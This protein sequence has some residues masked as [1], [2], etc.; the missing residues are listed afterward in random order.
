MT[1]DKIIFLIQK[2]KADEAKT[3]HFARLMNS[4]LGELHLIIGLHGDSPQDC[5][6]NFAVEY[7]EMAPRLIEC[8]EACARE[9]DEQ[10]LFQPFIDTAINYFIQP[11]VIFS[12]Y[13]GLDGLLMNAYLCHRLIEEMYENN[14]S[15]R[16]SNLVDVK[17]T[18]ANLL[19]HHLIGE[20]FSNELDQSI[21]ITVCQLMGAPSYYELDLNPFVRQ[22]KHKA[23]N[24]M[25]DYWNSLLERNQIRFNFSMRS[26]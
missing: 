14:K 25:R 22:V 11:S 13:V 19:A 17:T 2:A 16:N 5:L 20:P 26:G 6:F 8:V 15:I 23:W 21:L 4:K 9:A 18:E 10:D 12:K 3:G 7:I 1:P 24:W